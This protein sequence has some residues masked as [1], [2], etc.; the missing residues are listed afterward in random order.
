[1][2]RVGCGLSFSSGTIQYFDACPPSSTWA[3]RSAG[4]A[5]NT[6]LGLGAVR[7]ISPVRWTMTTSKVPAAP[8]RA[9]SWVTVRSSAVRTLDASPVAMPATCVCA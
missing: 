9:C 3:R 1:M 4:R 8:L 6:L 5:W 7:S 2:S